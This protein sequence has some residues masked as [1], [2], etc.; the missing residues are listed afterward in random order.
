MVYTL[1]LTAD[2]GTVMPF[3][4]P[5]QSWLPFAFV[6]NPTFAKFDPTG[7]GDSA[8]LP[9]ISYNDQIWYSDS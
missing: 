5:N 7:T 4:Y 8:Y 6:Y 9:L 3:N 1:G 2:E